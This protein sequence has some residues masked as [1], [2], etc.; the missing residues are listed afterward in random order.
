[1]PQVWI[2]GEPNDI[3]ALFRNDSVNRIGQERT[4][5]RSRGRSRSRPR[6]T[7]DS[8][9]RPSQ[10]QGP[11]ACAARLP[12]HKPF[13]RGC[14]GG[15]A[16][17]PPKEHEVGKAEDK[18]GL[19]L[20]PN[21][22]CSS[23]P[24]VGRH[25][26]SPAPTMGGGVGEMDSSGSPGKGGGEC[27][28]VREAIEPATPQCVAD[29]SEGEGECAKVRDAIEP[30]TSQCI[31]SGTGRS[32]GNPQGKCSG[33]SGGLDCGG[34]PGQ[35]GGESDGHRKQAK[36]HGPGLLKTLAGNGLQANPRGGWS[37]AEPHKWADICS[38][39][40]ADTSS[41]CCQSAS[42]Q[43]RFE[44]LVNERDQLM[45]RVHDLAMRG[46]PE[47]LEIEREMLEK[48]IRDSQEQFVPP[49][50]ACQTR[51]REFKAKKGGGL[52]VV[53]GKGKNNKCG[54]VGQQRAPR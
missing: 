12:F 18:V 4:S 23:A 29:P 45:K 19:P 27:A 16:R 48:Q 47:M 33:T 40:E 42:E 43:L 20:R 44:E 30:A 53:E 1:M 6:R 35:A 8:A 14:G 50:L 17:Q 38:D 3:R 37:R 26:R 34:E 54:K 32:D 36:T 25:G 10:A 28:E 24:M 51:S 49:P 13:V 46:N 15:E 5:P 9:S 41:E 52:E 7:N 21:R 22:R 39:G 11:E 2:V 31:A